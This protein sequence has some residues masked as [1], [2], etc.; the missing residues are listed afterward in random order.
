MEFISPLLSVII[1]AIFGSFMTYMA[2]VKIKFAEK[3]LA[4]KATKYGE[5]IVNLKILVG[6]KE[7]ATAS[8]LRLIFWLSCKKGLSVYSLLS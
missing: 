5:L 8:G 4:Y 3:Q 7:R 2:T 1:G 6:S